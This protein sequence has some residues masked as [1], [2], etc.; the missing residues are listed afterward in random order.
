[1][2]LPSPH[3]IPPVQFTL[4]LLF[5]SLN[6]HAQ[7]DRTIFG[8]VRDTSEGRS[9]SSASVLLLRPADSV[10][11]RTVRTSSDGVFRMQGIMDGTYILMVSFPKY[12]DYLDTIVI[13]ATDRDLHVI[14]LTTRAQLLQEV[15]I[16]RTAAAIRMKGDTTEY[17]ADSF[18]VAPNAD[19]QELLRRMPGI[20]VNARGEITTQGEKVTKV[21]VDGEEFFSDDPAVVTRNLR[22][23]V[24]D[25][26]Q[27]FDKKSDQATF[28]GIDDGQREKTI[29]LTLKEDKKNGYF[30]RL[31]GGTDFNRYHNGKA[32]GNYFKAKHKIAGY[33]T[34]DNSRYETLDWNDAQNYSD[35]GNTTTTVNEDG[36]VSITYFGNED[37]DVQAGLPNQQTAGVT[38]R[39]KLSKGDVMTNLQYQRLGSQLMGSGYTRTL[40]KDAAQISS[41]DKDQVVDRSRIKA[42][43]LYEWGTDSTGLLKMSVRGVSTDR[44]L[45]VKYT[46]ASFLE[47]GQNI[48]SS[49]RDLTN[50]ETDR[51][52]STVINY[53]RKLEKKGRTINWSTEIKAGE[54]SEDGSLRTENLFIGTGGQ[55]NQTERID[56]RK[57]SD[58]QLF[59]TQSNFVY[60]E[61]LGKKS[62]LI[63]KYGLGIARNDA[64]RLSF[65]RDPLGAYTLRVDT[66]SN[67]FLFNTLDNNGSLSYRY[68]YKKLNFAVSTGIG[69]TQYRRTDLDNRAEGQVGFVNFLPSLNL[70]YKPKSQRT[71]DIDYAGR[72]VN[73]TLQQL[74][75]I[76]TNTDP[77]NLL[78]GNPDLVQGFTH[79][80]NM[81]V[82]DYKVLKSRFI[83]LWGNF[84]ATEK[85]ITNSSFVNGKGLRTTKYVNTDGNF[86]YS[87]RAMYNV[88]VFNK[89]MVGAQLGTGFSRY[90]NLVNGER[91]VNDNRNISYTL[92][93]N[94]WSE[95]W[96]SYYLSFT[97]RQHHAVSS[98][99][100]KLPTKYWSYSAYGNVSLSFKKIKT[101]IDLPLELTM[102]QRTAVF[103]QA[104]NIWLV[105]PSLRKT[106]TKN[107]KLEAKLTVFDLL[108]QNSYVKRDVNSNFITEN[109]QNGI[110]RNI[111]FSLLFHFSRNGK[112]MQ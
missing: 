87:L 104:R 7:T 83:A 112:P 39:Q 28:T 29:N 67:H 3:R 66:L 109:T 78:I 69:K 10:L 14:P 27:V 35:G 80:V 98:L 81:N 91:N 23:D 34:T 60:T 108:N 26:V 99:R 2:R 25:K 19:V 45:A 8:R 65:D 96:L 40:L 107:D 50:N 20:Q 55:P 82:R 77:L 52:L 37:E 71:F 38:F 13:S 56:Q 61:P 48:N 59:N 84:S 94:Y 101:W 42:N 46:G 85:A 33:L 86:N 41:T 75:P 70:A 73:P 11:I 21:L 24:V 103:S 5:I 4:F 32:L 9:L 100:S 6:I 12:A 22:A 53:R 47:D 102:Y 110:R 88:Q 31:E 68:V 54:K 111:M 43:A 16:R 95:K 79:S 106:L 63:M 90:V 105:N 57:Q 17:R 1:M 93:S 58:Q 64:E 30:G 92:E 76:V 97:A 51:D 89:I 36:G 49:S 74:Q 72:P 62:F 44:K 15:I 18:H